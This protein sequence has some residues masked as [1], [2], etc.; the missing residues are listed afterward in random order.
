MYCPWTS[1]KIYIIIFFLSCFRSLLSSKFVLPFLVQT[2]R[3]RKFSVECLWFN[4]FFEFTKIHG[5]F[6]A[7]VF[8]RLEENKD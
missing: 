2:N 5:M 4:K 1:L 6:F 7:V 8:F 3:P